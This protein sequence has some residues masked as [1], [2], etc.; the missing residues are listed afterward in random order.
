MGESFYTCKLGSVS[1]EQWKRTA[2]EPII[3]RE[4]RANIANE[5]ASYALEQ[6]EW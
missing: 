6:L 1:G 5:E 2:N 4:E 3:G